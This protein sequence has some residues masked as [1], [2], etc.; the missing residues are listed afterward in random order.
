MVELAVERHRLIVAEQPGND[1][2]PL[3]EAGEAPSRRR[4]PAKLS[5]E[6][7]CQA[8]MTGCRKET[9]ETRGPNSMRLVFSAIQ[10]SE[11]HS[12]RLSLYRPVCSLGKWSE[13]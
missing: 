13:R 8:V 11:A 4:P 6:E 10:A 2:E 1:L 3:L 5:T 9:G 7:A 12:S